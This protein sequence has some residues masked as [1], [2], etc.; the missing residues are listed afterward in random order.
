[1]HVQLSSI[2]FV[3]SEIHTTT[4]FYVKTLSYYSG[5]LGFQIDTKKKNFVRDHSI[6]LKLMYSIG[7]SSL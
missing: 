1:M 2:M 5:H 6:I 3:L 4:G 7:S